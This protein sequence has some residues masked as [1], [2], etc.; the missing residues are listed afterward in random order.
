MFCYEKL[1][2]ITERNEPVN[3]GLFW[4]QFDFRELITY[5][6]NLVAIDDQPRA[7]PTRRIQRTPKLAPEKVETVAWDSTKEILGTR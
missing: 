5:R 2:L 3:F 1:D 7:A 4:R 6:D